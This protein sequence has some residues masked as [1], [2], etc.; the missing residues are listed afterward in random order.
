MTNSHQLTITID[1]QERVI[2]AV[3][4]TDEFD[5]QHL[6]LTFATAYDVLETWQS[7]APDHRKFGW[8][9]DDVVPE[10]AFAV[11]VDQAGT[12]QIEY[13]TPFFDGVGILN[14]YAL[15]ELTRLPSVSTTSN[16]P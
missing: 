9:I 16:L 3:T 10:T 4:R 13:L 8:T 14:E 1:G 2:P 12:L 7:S 11:W 6:V 5:Q 15:G